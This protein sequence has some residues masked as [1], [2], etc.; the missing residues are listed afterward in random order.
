MV[1]VGFAGFRATLVTLQRCGWAL[2]AHELCDHTRGPGSRNIQ[3]LMERHGLHLL[4]HVEMIPVQGF[5][6]RSFDFGLQ[7]RFNGLP[8]RVDV[9]GVQLDDRSHFISMPK[10]MDLEFLNTPSTTP[11]YFHP[12]DARPAWKQ[13]DLSKIS[14]SEFGVFK[15]LNDTASIYL[16]EKTI[17]EILDEV[18]K[19]QEP[20]QREIRHNNKRREF[21]DDMSRDPKEEI[22]A[23]LIAI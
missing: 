16:P 21:M 17:A 3:L 11:G 7:N 6:E 10:E 12:I 5:H 8:A 22:K 1:E 18:L 2:S 15:R 14:M 13:I 23:Q 20:K 4:S 9:V 19:K